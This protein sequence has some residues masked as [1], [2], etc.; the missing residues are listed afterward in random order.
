MYEQHNF[1]E[2]AADK[3]RFTLETGHLNKHTYSASYKLQILFKEN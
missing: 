3:L 1:S 2:L